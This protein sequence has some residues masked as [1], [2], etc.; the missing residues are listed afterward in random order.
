M[1]DSSIKDRIAGKRKASFTKRLNEAIIYAIVLEAFFIGI[2]PIA[3]EICLLAGFVCFL[4]KWV[5]DS[6]YHFQRTRYFKPITVFV[7]CGLLSIT[8]SPDPGFSFYNFYN[9]VGVYLLTYIMVTQNLKNMSEVKMVFKGLGYSAVLI[10]AYGLF[11]YIFGIDTADMKWV[12]GEAFPELKKRIFS[13]WE[14]PN[15]FAA[16]LDILI[17]ILLGIFVKLDMEKKYRKQW[18]KYLGVFMLLAAFCLIMTYARGALLTICVV[19]ALY[20]IMKDWRI[21]AVLA[22]VGGVAL[23]ANPVLL[24]RI[25]NVFAVADTSSEMRLAMW[26]STVQMIMDHPILGI[27]W[28]AYWMVYPLYDFY[29]VDGS[30]MLVHAHNIYLNYV[31]E[32]GIIGGIAYFVWFFG[33][34][35]NALLAKNPL[36]NDLSEGI[37]LGLG[38]ALVTVALNGL[39]DDVLFNIPSSML[40]WMMCGLIQVINKNE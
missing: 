23:A 8:G 24:D 4:I 14:N 20:G 7:V 15:I 39:T 37:R 6:E 32:I 40:L 11:Q 26:E 22:V 35:T 5:K 31:A 30:V 10:I 29:I 36:D 1:I 12:D 25:T 28:G 9:L 27:G 21:L 2:Y 17:C 19:A 3:A 18:R 33:N 16:Y 13:T 34:M 38:L